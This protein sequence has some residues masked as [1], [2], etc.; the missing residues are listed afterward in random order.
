VSPSRR[1]PCGE[2]A[3]LLGE[4]V[5]RLLDVSL[6]GVEAEDASVRRAPIANG[7]Y[8]WRRAH[9]AGPHQRRL[10][11]LMPLPLLMRVAVSPAHSRAGSQPRTLSSATSGPV[12]ELAGGTGWATRIV[13]APARR[14][15]R[16]GRR[17]SRGRAR[18]SR[19]PT[20]RTRGIRPPSPVQRGRPAAYNCPKGA[21]E[22]LRATSRTDS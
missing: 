15:R 16:T 21:R 12:A 1:R 2:N 20:L 7:G 14:G 19:N 3:T 5:G 17:P 13:G 8:G 6:V 9:A 11:A 18:H 10:A 4:G 22:R